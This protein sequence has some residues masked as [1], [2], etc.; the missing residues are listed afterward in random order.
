MTPSAKKLKLFAEVFIWG[1]VFLGYLVWLFYKWQH[2]GH[3]PLTD[4]T[5]YPQA[6]RALRFFYDSGSREP[7][8]ICFIKILL[9]LI[10]PDEFALRLGSLLCTEAAFVIVILWARSQYGLGASMATAL[11][12]ALNPIVS[13]YACQAYNICGYA[14]MLMLFFALWT[15]PEKS[16]LHK[17]WVGLAG[18]LVALTRLE[19][20]LVVTLCLIYQLFKSKSGQI[21]KAALAS[22]GLAW[23]ITA[24]YL[25]YQKMT[26]GHFFAS[27]RSHAA[28]WQ[29][30][31]QEIKTETPTPSF[32]RP[33]LS[34][35]F[36]Q[37]GPAA[38]VLRFI[39]GYLLGFFW[40]L[41]RLWQGMPVLLI[42]ALLGLMRQWQN[43]QY[44]LTM[45]LLAMLA[46]IAYILP[47]DQIAPG[48]G[49][50]LRFALPLAW[51]S[52]LL[53]GLGFACIMKYLKHKILEETFYHGN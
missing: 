31:E 47:L 3:A 52:A 8:Y 51:P 28:F 4:P 15:S 46:P 38:L 12:L 40:Y 18:G 2:Y 37:Q 13:Y 44:E 14:A 39:K 42:L 7:L 1:V 35:F 20:L 49:L 9:A 6:A 29:Q 5:A 16:L 19:G 43:K 50:E 30:R 21:Q 48:S 45:A 10:Q 27:H 32:P 23:V 41:P 53:M 11:T 33:S 22:L 25:V 26:M 17:I 36:L 24:P 34:A